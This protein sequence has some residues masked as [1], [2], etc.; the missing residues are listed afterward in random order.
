MT[1]NSLSTWIQPVTSDVNMW[2]SLIYNTS[3]RQVR[4]ECDTNAIQVE[5]V[6]HEWDTSNTS[7]TQTARV[8]HDCYTNDT[9]VTR[10]KN[11]DFDNDTRK[12]IFSHP[13]IYYMASER[14]QGDEQLHSKNYL[15][16]M[17]CSHAKMRLKSA[18]QKLNFLMAKD[19]SK[20]YTL[21]CSCTLMS[22]RIPV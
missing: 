8:R 10:V 19:I 11:I 1:C 16:K 3:A 9:S 14:S 2:S 7:P 15:L 13:Y 22:L 12:N 5:G 21:D 18:P 4:H 6:Q 17:P 20:C